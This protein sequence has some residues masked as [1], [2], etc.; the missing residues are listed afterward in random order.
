MNDETSVAESSPEATTE[1]QEPVTEVSPTSPATPQNASAGAETPAS[2]APASNGERPSER[3]RVGTQR[4][5]GDAAAPAADLRP[6]PVNPVTEGE[7]Q[8]KSSGK[9]YPPPNIRT[10]PTDEEEAELASLMEGS[11]VDQVLDSEQAAAPQELPEG[12]KHKAKIVRLSGDSVF[13]ELGTHLQGVV[14]LKQFDA[15]PGQQPAAAVAPASD[16]ALQATEGVPAEAEPDVSHLPIEGDEIDVI[17]TSYNPDEGTYE[18]SL[19]SAPQD[20]GDWDEVETGK[21]VEVTITG[22]NK[23]GLECKVAGI[24]GFMPTGQISIYRVENPEEYIGQRLTAV[25]TEA[26]RARKNVILSHRAVMERER[27]EMKDKLLAELAPGQLRE[28]VVRSL[29]D[30][31][32]FV[33]LGGVDGLIHVSKLSWDR[34]GHPREVLSEGQSV[35]VKIEKIDPASGKIAL[36]Y[37]ETAANPWDSAEADFPVG[38]TIKGKVTKT[39]DFGAFVRLGPGVEGMI[40]ISEL[41]YKRVHRVTDVLK[42]GQDVEAKVLSVDRG[43]QRIALSLKALM[44]A[45]AKPD[46]KEDDYP[47]EE[48]GPKQERKEFK[49]LKGG[50]GAPSGGEKFGLKW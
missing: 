8:P 17:V 32:A 49:N 45:P 38:S 46:P 29:R 22:K 43:K 20:I 26:N 27:A 30:F 24:R 35:K 5:E 33:D 42:E 44:A 34:I 28:G 37:R 1:R 7:P 4:A 50:I 14:P 19:P 23:G 6:K 47:V 11:S 18:L 12:S 25:I 48:E 21:I 3:L 2:E 9:H 31:G 41:D 40:H 13:V 16:T 36:S 15:K 39:M 10:A